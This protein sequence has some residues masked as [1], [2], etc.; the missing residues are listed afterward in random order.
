MLPMARP[1]LGQTPLPSLHWQAGK[2]ALL[3]RH[4]RG[5]GGPQAPSYPTPACRC[6]RSAPSGVPLPL[7]QTALLWPGRRVEQKG[8]PGA[9]RGG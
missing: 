7:T 4:E 5:R 3:P 6:P 1:S 8:E 2:V 9:K